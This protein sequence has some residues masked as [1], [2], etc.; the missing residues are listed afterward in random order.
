MV[1]GALPN[2]RQTQSREALPGQI[3]AIEASK[4]LQLRQR[5]ADR[6]PLTLAER[7]QV[8]K[9]QVQPPSNEHVKAPGAGRW[10]QPW[11]RCKGGGRGR[12]LTLVL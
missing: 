11:L 4:D 10:D 7:A 6:S 9:Q 5:A 8:L 1:F 12:G 3:L 2:S